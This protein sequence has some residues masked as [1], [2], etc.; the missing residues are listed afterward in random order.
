MACDERGAFRCPLFAA[1]DAAFPFKYGPACKSVLREFG[2]NAAEIHLPVAQ[3]AE[4]PCPVNPRLVASV[5]PLPSRGMELRVFDVKHL[6]VAVIKINELQIVE[7]LQ[8]K[9]AG[10][11]QNMATGM[12]F[13]S[14]Q[15]HFKRRAIVQ[16]FP[17]M[18]LET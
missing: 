18:D 13:Y 3:R 17:G 15:E 2:K 9:M 16:V 10:I 8:H 5:Y 6:D 1:L 14:L 11:K 7:L 12:I 4:A